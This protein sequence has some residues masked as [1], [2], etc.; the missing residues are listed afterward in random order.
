MKP[1]NRV[2]YTEHDHCYNKEKIGFP[3]G[4]YVLMTR[5]QCKSQLYKHEIKY[6]TRVKSS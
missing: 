6:Y 3:Y 1:R 5:P 4:C 2:Q